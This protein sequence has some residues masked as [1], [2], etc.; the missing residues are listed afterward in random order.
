MRKMAREPR[1][2]LVMGSTSD[3]PQVE[4]ALE[5]LE[6]LK[7][8]YTTR[9]LSAHRTPEALREFAREAHEKGIHVII[10]CAGAAAHLAGVI[11][12]HTDL[13]VI[14]VPMAGTT[15]GG[16]DALFSTVQMPGGVP[17]ATMG[18]GAAGAKNAVL[19]AARVLALQDPGL[20]E[21][22]ARQREAQAAQV[23][24]KDEEIRKQRTWTGEE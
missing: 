8:P 9:I 11:S 16:L 1:V 24:E 23:L 3:L 5:I 20:A 7:I 14:G 19:M 15:L 17:V 22:L 6:N 18:I 10:A 21:K 2:A 13:P 12:S 4:P